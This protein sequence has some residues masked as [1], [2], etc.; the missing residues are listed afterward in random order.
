[1]SDTAAEAPEGSEGRAYVDRWT[2]YCLGHLLRHPKLPPQATY[3]AAEMARMAEE[4]R[5]A[6]DE[7]APPTPDKEG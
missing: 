1:M 2:L 5:R 4:V 7:S 3:T 6:Y